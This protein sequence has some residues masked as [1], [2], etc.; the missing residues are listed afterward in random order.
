MIGTILAIDD[1]EDNL[2]LLEA[3]LE[4]QEFVFHGASSGL[5]GL[6]LARSIRPDLVLLDLV[7]P[8]MDGFEV[9]AT[10]RADPPLRNVP[11]IILTANNREYS[12]IERGF[13]LGATE[14]LTKPIHM[15]ELLVRIRTTMRLSRAEREL[16]RLRRDFASMLVHDMRAPLDGVRLALAALRRQEASDSPRAELLTMALGSLVDVGNLIE[17]LLN[18]NQLDDEG[19]TA[20]LEPV[21]MAGLVS[22]SVQA[23]RPIADARGLA[24]K[25]V[26]PPVE[27]V[28]EVDKRLAKRVL[29]NLL[30][31]ALKF[32]DVGE[33]VI[34]LLARAGGV[35][36]S[37]SDT[38][39]G[40]APEILP[41]IFDRY[42]HLERRN[43]NRQGGL[44]LG[45]AFC[46]RAV[47]A[48]GG[49]LDVESTLDR[50]STFRVWLPLVAAPMVLAK[51]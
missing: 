32:T 14:F 44:G 36:I 11:V 4:A 43:A 8:G 34:S 7:M 18:V 20:R 9:L 17:D 38:G 50:G 37:V 42:F 26:L 30:A 49:T 39:P 15:E 19:F 47:N 2:A 41:Q 25:L 3:A 13:E 22:G 12:V 45:L 51:L 28:A 40:I 46:R 21:D 31:N 24:L 48:M 16:E 29:D 6:A 1:Q 35:E 5:T 27:L 10:L 33:V 23:L